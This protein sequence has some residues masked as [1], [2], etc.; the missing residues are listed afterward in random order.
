MLWEH[1]QKSGV[2]AR[3]GFQITSIARLNRREWQVG[4]RHT[5]TGREAAVRTA[6]L[7]GADG[8]RSFVARSARLAYPVRSS[9]FGVKTHG[10]GRSAPG[11]RVE[12]HL[13]S[14][15]YT[16]IIDLKGGHRNICA[17]LDQTAIQK[18][19]GHWNDFVSVIFSTNPFLRARL[20][21]F[22]RRTPPIFTGPM[23]YGIRQGGRPRLLIGDAKGIVDQ[24]SGSGI[25]LA[26]QSASRLAELMHGF[27]EKRW[28]AQILLRRYDR[29]FRALFRP[30]A[31]SARIVRSL[32]G[33]PDRAEWLFTRALGDER[34]ARAV[35]STFLNS[36]GGRSWKSLKPLLDFR[37]LARSPFR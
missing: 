37:L 11:H 36:S 32:T 27:F 26:F 14:R 34:L 1:A 31:W 28:T 20:M 8:A 15:G 17:L 18:C 6:T 21:D 5:M 25:L 22:E 33:Q 24:F 13:L 29:A 23:A 4:G 30:V 19:G 2:D 12:L 9:A 3:Q 16:G 10:V 35:A 7:V